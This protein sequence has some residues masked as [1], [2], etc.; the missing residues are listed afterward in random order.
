MGSQSKLCYVERRM[1]SFLVHTG[2]NQSL[3]FTPVVNVV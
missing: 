2:D 3:T 1:D